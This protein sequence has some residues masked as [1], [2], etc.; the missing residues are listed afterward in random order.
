[1]Y[2]KHNIINKTIILIHIVYIKNNI[3]Y[4]LVQF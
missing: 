3:S 1:M 2:K 4:E